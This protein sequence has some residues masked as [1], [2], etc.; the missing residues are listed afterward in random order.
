MFQTAI[1]KCVFHRYDVATKKEKAEINA[2]IICSVRTNHLQSCSR[3]L[4]M[5]YQWGS[6]PFS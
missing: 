4:V 3:L 5:K 1:N 2:G 6:L